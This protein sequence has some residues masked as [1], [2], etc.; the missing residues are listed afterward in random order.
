[1]AHRRRSSLAPQT[2]FHMVPVVA[3]HE[4]IAKLEMKII[5]TYAQLI[6][7]LQPKRGSSPSI[8][9]DGVV[10]DIETVRTVFFEELPMVSPHFSEW[11]DLLDNCERLDLLLHR[12][13]SL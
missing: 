2:P 8:I 10:P 3:N 13:G 11:E 12:R 5:L 9:Q 7:H 4:E 6:S 1:M